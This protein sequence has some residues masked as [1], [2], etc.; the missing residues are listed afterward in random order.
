[1]PIVEFLNVE[2]HRLLINTRREAIS[3]LAD[4]ELALNYDGEG[5]MTGA[6]IDGRNYLRSLDNHIVEKQE[7][8]RPGL[9]YRV[10]RE[11]SSEQGRR[12]L[13]RV[14]GLVRGY[15]EMV[16]NPGTKVLNEAPPA[17]CRQARQ[18]LDYILACEPTRL[19]NE[20]EQF[21]RIY[22]PINILPP[23]QY[24]ALV[25]QATEG[26]SY[27]RCTFCGFYRDRSFRIKPLDEFKQHIGDVRQ[28]VASGI[29]LRRSIFL[30]DANAL[31]IPQDQLLPLFDT[32]NSEFEFEPPHLKREAL[33]TWKAKHP[34]YMKGIY[35]FIDAFTTRRKTAGDFA[36]L[37]ARGL[38]RVYIGLESGDEEVLKFLGKPNSPEDV[39]QLAREVKAGGVAVGLIILAGAGGANLAKAHVQHTAEII[40][41]MPVDAD[42]LVYF[43]ELID[44]PGS[45]YSAL[46]R[47]RDIRPL[48]VEEIGQQME[49]MRAGLHFRDP[50]HAPKVSYYDV[51]EFIY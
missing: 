43:S 48:S 19:E 47:E 42:D 9:S 5:R 21:H 50:E 7:G 2:G 15:R 1:M 22:K 3:I 39:L 45:N 41:A 40:N 23:D 24:M 36:E 8:P 46:A 6:W 13:S 51:R 25:L 49:Q 37:A 16:D 34:V 14:Y 35:S 27:N 4:N 11:L 28:L 33:E 31:V 29:Q 44:Y 10:R 30:A 20:S 17:E 32:V 38:R 26:C 12:L 18:S